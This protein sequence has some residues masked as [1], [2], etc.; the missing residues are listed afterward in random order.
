MKSELIKMLSSLPSLSEDEAIEI[1]EVINIQTFKKGTI[2]LREGDISKE[3]YSV[4]KGCVRE[5]YIKAG[6]EKTNN[7]PRNFGTNF[8]LIIKYP[9]ITR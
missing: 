4:L 9:I 6:E 3:C 7:F 2:L 8:D 1:V 5:Y